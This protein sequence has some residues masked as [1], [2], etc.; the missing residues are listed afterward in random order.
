MRHPVAFLKANT[1][2]KLYPI[3]GTPEL[4]REA[5]FS[6]DM[7]EEKVRGYHHRIQNES[8][9]AFLDMLLLK[10]PRP[11][12]VKTPV[13]V[14]GAAN[15]TIFSNN[16]VHASAQAYQTKAEIFDDMAHDMMLEAGW[17]SVADRMLR[18]L[19]ERGMG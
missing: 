18:W 9:R 16:E 13:L 12:R 19:D 14:L 11:K 8:Y 6:A 3:V 1:T 15:D 5:F 4:T 17:Q 7:H 10:L 2:L